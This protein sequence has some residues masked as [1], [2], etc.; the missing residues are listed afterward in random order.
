MT[1]NFDPDRWYEREREMLDARH[2]A[3]EISTPEYKNAL[4]ELERRLFFLV[5]NEEGA[6]SWAFPVTVDKTPHRL[7]FSTGER[8]HGA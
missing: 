1:Y 7:T 5:R 2:R 3:G 8:L 6:V 4:A